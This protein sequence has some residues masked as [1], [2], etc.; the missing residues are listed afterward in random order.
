MSEK[1][2]YFSLFTQTENE[3]P[4]IVENQSDLVDDFNDKIEKDEL[5]SAHSDNVAKMPA[6]AKKA[7]VYLMRQGVVLQSQKPQVFAN[8]LQYEEMIMRHLS[9]VYLSLIID[10]RQGILFIARSDYQETQDEQSD[11]DNETRDEDDISSLINRKTISVYDSLLLLILRK[12][13]Q[14]RENSGEQQIIIDID[15]LEDLL[16]PFLPLTNYEGKGKK[17]LLGRINSL[18]KPHKIVQNI[19]NSDERFEI[20]PMIRYVVNAN[21][22]HAMLQEYEQLLQKNQENSSDLKQPNNQSKKPSKTPNNSNVQ[23]DLF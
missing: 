11:F 23:T 6:I 8:I 5:P 13:Y 9:E 15:K 20:T 7:L 22:L 16:S 18:L 10:E 19:R 12:Y 2:D 4:P 3:Y 14:E 17:Q 21:F 1:I